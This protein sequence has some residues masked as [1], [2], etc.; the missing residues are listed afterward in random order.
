MWA[1]D[2]TATGKFADVDEPL[3]TQNRS[4]EGMDEP[5]NGGKSGGKNVPNVTKDVPKSVTKEV[6]N[7]TKDGGKDG[8]KNHSQESASRKSRMLR[9]FIFIRYN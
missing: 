7:V 9:C 5:N 1:A 2:A 6:L 8:V 3:E 4:L